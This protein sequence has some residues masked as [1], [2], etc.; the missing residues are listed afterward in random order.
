MFDTIYIAY[1]IA[2]AIFA[3]T[4]PLIQTELVISGSSVVDIKP[5]PTSILTPLLIND[6]RIWPAY[7]VMGVALMSLIAITFGTPIVQ[8]SLHT[9][10]Y[11]SISA[12]NNDEPVHSNKVVTSVSSVADSAYFQQQLVG[13]TNNSI[14]SYEAHN[15]MN[16]YYI[17]PVYPQ[18]VQLA[19][20]INSESKQ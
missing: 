15:P 14:S 8:K 1:N 6:S 17:T 19:P 18:L 10:T 13:S 2:Q 5:M 11:S 16:Y 3:G 20:V 4:A 12:K 9:T 7:Y